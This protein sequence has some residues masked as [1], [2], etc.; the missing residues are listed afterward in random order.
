MAF[1]DTERLIIKE[2]PINSTF[3][4]DNIEYK[5]VKIGKPCPSKGECKT[6]TYILAQDTKGTTKEFKI[7]V[8]QSNADFL[9]NKMTLDRALEIFG[10]DASKIM[11]EAIQSIKKSFEDDFLIHFRTGHRTDAKSMKIGWKFELMNKLSGKL[12]GKIDLTQS[13]ILDVYAGTNLP[14]DK[15]NCMVNNSTIDESGVANYIWV[16]DTNSFDKNTFFK[17]IKPIAEYIKDKSIY[18]AC[19]A[20]NYR[21]VPNKWDGNRPLS[22]YVDWKLDNGKLSAKLVFDK[23]LEIYA[24]TIGNKIIEQL[25]TLNIAANNFDDLKNKIDN[26]IKYY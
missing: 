9:E 16:G 23:P 6:D 10:K 11:T 19:K 26:S 14:T 3:K 17:E 24:N 12:S 4:H 8:K 22:V 13:Q 7:S 25:S 18:F 2:F 5:I 1:G 15:R 20:I 21:A